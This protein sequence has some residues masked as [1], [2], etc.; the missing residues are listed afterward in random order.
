M[1]RENWNSRIVDK[2]GFKP[3]NT[4]TRKLFRNI[5]IDGQKTYLN[6]Q[7]IELIV[8]EMQNSCYRIRNPRH[9]FRK[10][11]QE[12]SKEV[13]SI[14]D[15]DLDGKVSI[16]EFNNYFHNRLSGSLES[17]FSYLPETGFNPTKSSLFQVNESKFSLKKSSCFNFKPQIENRTRR[18]LNQIHENIEIKNEFSY[19]HRQEERSC[20]V[21]VESERQNSLRKTNKVDIRASHVLNLNEM[22]PSRN[23]SEADLG[24]YTLQPF[25]S[26]SQG[27]NNLPNSKT[28]LLEQ[29]VK[30]PKSGAREVE[31]VLKENSNIVNIQKFEN[32]RK[33]SGKLN[34]DNF[35][36]P[37]LLNNV[38]QSH[39][40]KYGY[41]ERSP[42]KIK[43]FNR[44]RDLSKMTEFKE[45][46][47]L[48]F[49]TFKRH[50]V[51]INLNQMANSDDSDIVS[52]SS[53]RSKRSAI[54]GNKFVSFQEKPVGSLNCSIT[55]LERYKRKFEITD[56]EDSL[57]KVLPSPNRP[58]S[59]RIIEVNFNETPNKEK[60]KKIEISPR[61]QPL[62]DKRELILSEIP[63]KKS[64]PWIRDP[65]RKSH[66]IRDHSNENDYNSFNLKHHTPIS[67]SK[68]SS[69]RN[70]FRVN[71]GLRDASK[72]KIIERNSRA[73]SS[74]VKRGYESGQNRRGNGQ[75]FSPEKKKIFKGNVWQDNNYASERGNY[76]RDYFV[77]RMRRDEGKDYYK[78]SGMD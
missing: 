35:D 23:Q 13:I 16:D 19:V 57:T 69:S 51:Q 31:Y 1:N 12:F 6:E 29:S 43:K 45:E 63:Q 58:V 4:I 66:Y 78:F 21:D 56:F 64:R 77:G 30:S 26:F 70:K 54:S 14:L 46:N 60:K 67:Q 65:L 53:K 10:S 2:N 48:R 75:C 27:F 20:D 18:P 71:Y 32:N 7:D 38:N 24:K 5:G 61:V 37:R 52:V 41:R 47:N 74:N 15:R 59:G 39:T 42:L 55:S 8:R 44:F 28:Q 25:T 9:E 49:S 76:R 62:S 17:S 50:N 22:V 68:Y 3:I 34:F 11:H 73:K 40:P 33:K 36:K 72:S